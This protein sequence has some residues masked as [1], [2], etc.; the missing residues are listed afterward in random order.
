MNGR[1]PGLG[2]G[3]FAAALALGCSSSPASE[4]P[5]TVDGPSAVVVLT[6]ACAP[7]SCNHYLSV[8][9]Q[10]PA[11]GV[12]DRSRAL[13]FGD[14]QG[15]VHNDAVYLFD[16][17]SGTV[18]RFRLSPSS[19]LEA[20]P[21]LSFRGL[22]V[23]FV[24]GILNAWAAPNRAFLLD[25]SSGQIVTW[26][27]VEMAIVATTSIPAEFL[28]RDG[29][30]TDFAWPA[31]IDDVV[32]YDA[33][34]FDFEQYAGS[35][36]AGTLRFDAGSDQPELT[37]LEE[38]RCGGISSSAPFAGP[39]GRVHVVGDG[40]GG[41]LTLLGIVSDPACALRVGP[42]GTGFDRDYALEL[43]GERALTLSAAWSLDGGAALLANAWMPSTPAALPVA[44]E[45]YWT[46]TEFGWMII[47]TQ[48]GAARP[49]DG[50]PLAGAGNLTPLSLDGVRHVQIYPP[51]PDGMYPEAILYAVR[52]DGSAEPVLRGGPAGDFEM[53]GRISVPVE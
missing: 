38:E 48:T 34:W 37:L 4:G 3:A 32:Y 19:E 12:V 27:P 21:I 2:V 7:D 18:Q 15:S 26:D 29:L 9:D 52:S 39:D 30:R 53:I 47:D 35:A 46:S 50:I 33:Y 6:R 25:P 13:E 28:E 31:V 17:D 23:G 51:A 49:V 16:F 20:G 10:L 8:L 40:V 45:E 11:D 41:L 36:R 5:P 14:V 24:A 44:L 43:L 1:T 22:G 42:T